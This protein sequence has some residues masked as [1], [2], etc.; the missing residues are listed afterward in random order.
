MALILAAGEVAASSAQEIL[1]ATGIQGGLVVHLGCGDGKL[2]AG[3]RI[4]D[5]YRVHGLDR[6]D[7]NV[8]RAR[9]TIRSLGVYGEVSADRWM[10]EALPYTD[11]IVNLIVSEDLGDLSMD[12]VLR[13]LCPEGVAYIKENGKWVK[14][15]KPRPRAIDDWTHYLYDASNNAVAH[16]TVV[17]PPRHLQWIGSPRWARHHD[18]MASLNALVSAGGR[19]FYLFDEGSPAAILLPQKRVLR[20]RVQSSSHHCGTT[21]ASPP[22]GDP[23]S[24]MPPSGDPPS[25]MPPSPGSFSHRLEQPS[26]EMTFPSSQASGDS[27]VPFPHSPSNKS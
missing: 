8:Q 25:S 15:V 1:E 12:E 16:D 22:S 27:S 20:R 14:T 26:P 3:L 7:Q 2:T 11:G 23:P 18:R 21:P 10:G 17:G 13:V 9:E 19:L 6:K 5:S 4:N 24:R